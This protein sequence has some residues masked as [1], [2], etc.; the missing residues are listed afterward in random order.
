MIIALSLYINRF[1]LHVAIHRIRD[2]AI[3]A[4]DK[5]NI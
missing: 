4:A 1:L 5:G 3:E 2:M